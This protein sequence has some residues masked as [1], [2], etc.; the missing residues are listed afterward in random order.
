MLSSGIAAIVHIQ[1]SYYFLALS[2]IIVSVTAFYLLYLHKTPEHIGKLMP[3][4]SIM[5]YLLFVVGSF[6]QQDTLISLVWV[7]VYPIIYFYLTDH[8]TGIKLTVLSLLTYVVAYFSHPYLFITERIPQTALI[9]VISAY[10]FVAALAYFY[11][12]V[13]YRQEEDLQLQAELDYLTN[14]YNRRGLNHRLDIEINRVERYGTRLSFMLIDMDN[15]KL[16]NDTYGHKAGDKLLQEISQ[17]TLLSIRK[18][19]V[20]ARWGGE[21]FAIILPESDLSQAA[22]LAEKLRSIIATHT[23]SEIGHVTVSIGVT[24]YHL[25]ESQDQLLNRAD[26]ALYRAKS[27]SKNRVEI[28]AYPNS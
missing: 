16:V 17:L 24:Q 14:I 18:S 4:I 19:D 12:V 2:E 7:P 11:E 8:R 21:E 13:R 5:I 6:S 1:Q 25:P 20:L 3:I 22:Q 28:E 9:Q 26:T 10:V 15:F 23:F 27:F